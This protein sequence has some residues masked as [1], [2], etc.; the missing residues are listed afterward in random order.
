MPVASRGAA[1]CSRRCS[2]NAASRRPSSAR[3]LTQEEAQTLGFPGSPTIR[4][5]GRD[6]DPAGAGARP[7][8][9]CRIYHRRTG[10]Y[11]RSRAASNSRR[12]SREH[13]P[14]AADCAVF[15][16]PGVDG[17]EPRARR[18]PRRRALV[19]VQSCNHCPY[20]Q[21]W[22]GRLD[23]NRERLRRPRRP[24]RRDRSNDARAV[25]EDSFAEMQ[26]RAQEQ[27]F[28]FDYLY[29]EDQGSRGRSARSERP[30]C[31]SSTATEARLPRRDGRQPRRDGGCRRS[32]YAMRST[33]CSPGRAPAVADTPAVG[34]TVKWR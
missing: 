19:L 14:L 7:A 34:C 5:D 17:D 2:P 6:V 20:V 12:H 25:P 27:G 10:A 28:T 9:T 13:R 26:Q 23:R 1:S 31:S 3:V 32:T 21:A 33:R 16:L 15:D 30:R 8:L 18:L 22:E 24:R 4:V 29:D 11:R